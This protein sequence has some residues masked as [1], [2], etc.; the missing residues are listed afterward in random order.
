MLS[1]VVYFWLCSFS[2]ASWPINPWR[3]AQTE[4]RYERDWTYYSWPWWPIVDGPAGRDNSWPSGSWWPIV[5]AR[6]ERGWTYY[7]WPWWPI[8]WGAQCECSKM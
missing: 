6:A 5:D 8:H 7:S 4:A 1:S 3:E 2:I